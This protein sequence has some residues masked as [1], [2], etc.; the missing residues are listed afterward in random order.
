MQTY[1]FILPTTVFVGENVV[2][3]KASVLANL[4]KKAF[5]VTTAFP[6]GVENVCLTDTL[7]ALESQGIE[8]RVNDKALPNPPIK[9]VAEI[10]ED[11]IDFGPDFVIACGGGSPI[12][13]AKGVSV[14]VNYPGQ[15]PFYVF[16]ELINTGG[17]STSS[18][19]TANMVGIGDGNI[20]VVAIPT[21]AGTGAEMTSAAV[22][23]NEKIGTKM[24][25]DQRVFCTVAFIDY[26]YAKT[27]PRSL[28][29]AAAMDALTHGVEAYL[30]KNGNFLVQSFAKAG[31][32]LFAKYKDHLLSG[33]LTDEDF[34]N[35]AIASNVFGMSEMYGTT[36]THGMGYPLTEEKNVSHGMAC[37]VFLGEFLRG[38]KDQSIVKPIVEWCGFND[39]NEFADYVNTLLKPY[40]NFTCTN[41][42]INEWTDT[43]I[44]G[45]QKWR[46]PKNPEPLTWDDIHAIYVKSLG[47]AIKG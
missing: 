17:A 25:M 5:V 19:R 40:I 43:M 39:V 22:L 26:R 41:E 1:K 46:I 20:P 35:M 37:A 13:V 34:E 30:N 38:F 4:G 11:A 42:E 29:D 45:T 47:E 33:E 9:N 15:D 36:I 7:S 3:N 44:T 27:C 18:P 23:T 8:Y 10:A 24:S 12:D 21:T 14:L 28:R 6:E 31:F 32:E 16:Y 2:K